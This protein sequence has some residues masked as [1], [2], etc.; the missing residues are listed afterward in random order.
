MVLDD[1]SCRG[2]MAP[3]SKILDDLLDAF[4]VL[5]QL[6]NG[7]VAITDI[8]HE[9]TKRTGADVLIKKETTINL[10]K[11][12][13]IRTVLGKRRCES[14][15]SCI[16]QRL[17][18]LRRA[19]RHERKQ[20]P[21]SAVVDL[22]SNAKDAI[23]RHALRYDRKPASVASCTDSKSDFAESPSS[24]I[25]CGKPLSFGAGGLLKDLPKQ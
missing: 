19:L 12:G 6:N 7:L 8:A 13:T 1:D 14:G 17:R 3:T 22:N 15:R 10:C 24:A 5:K 25:C 16:G 23:E 4:A 9:R 18:R 2:S 11:P 20:V 21:S